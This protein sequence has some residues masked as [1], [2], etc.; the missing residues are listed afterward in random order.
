M[1]MEKDQASSSVNGNVL[2]RK[3]NEENPY[4][5]HSDPVDVPAVRKKRTDVT[6]TF[7]TNAHPPV[8]VAG[9]MTLPLWEPLEMSSVQNTSSPTSGTD[10]SKYARLFH[11]VE[12]GHYQYKF[13]LGSEGPWIVDESIEVGELNCV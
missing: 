8:F 2:P 13:R 4:P 5:S 6:I 7:E 1:T 11:V 3:M 12:E 10:P 9:S